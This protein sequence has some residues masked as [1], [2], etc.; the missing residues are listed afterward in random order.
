MSG[1]ANRRSIAWG[2][3]RAL[4]E[5]G[6]RVAITCVDSTENRVR[7]LAAEIDTDIVVPCDVRDDAAI[8]VAF[9][10]IGAAFDGRLDIFVHS[11]AFARLEDMGGE[12]IAVNREGWNL[13]LN[14]SAYSLVAMARA[15]RPF[16]VSAGGGSILTL[17]YMGGTRVTPTY[18]IMGIAKAAL[19]CA[20]RY[21]A[22]DLGP[23]KIR[24]NA[25][26]PGAIPT[27]SS[28]VVDRFDDAVKATR[29]RSPLLEEIKAED[30]GD[31]AVFYAS[32]LSR[33]ITGHTVRIDSG[34]DILAA[35]SG[36]HPRAREGGE[37]V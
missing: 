19:E 27:L 4:H 13:A 30:V 25:L 26:S 21:L 10:R 9:G 29:Q 33:M 8:E 20:V 2:V 17:S 16:M 3:A 15:A 6:A 14:V 32:D 37:S 34:L 5:H 7:K 22:Y 24:V 11:I 36:I 35:G 31:A 18:N 12:F 23:D 1:V 28:M